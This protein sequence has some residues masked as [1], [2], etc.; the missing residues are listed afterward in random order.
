MI[1]TIDTKSGR[2]SI[3]TWYTYRSTIR[4]S[5][6]SPDLEAFQ[7]GGPL[8]GLLVID[9]PDLIDGEPVFQWSWQ[10]RAPHV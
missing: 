5:G 7:E 9:A 2:H 1:S 10:G 6:R 3:T 8:S 4:G